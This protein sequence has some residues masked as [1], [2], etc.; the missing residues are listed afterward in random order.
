MCWE[1]GMFGMFEVPRYYALQLYL[2]IRLTSFRVVATASL[3][4]LSCSP[5]TPI[6]PLC[7]SASFSQLPRMRLH[8]GTGRRG[9]GPAGPFH[10]RQD[11]RRERARPRRQGHFSR[12]TS[13]LP[14]PSLQVPQPDVRD[15]VLRAV[16]HGAVPQGLRV[17]AVRCAMYKL[18]DVLVPILV[19]KMTPAIL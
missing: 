11:V 9:R 17:R 16:Q 10:S 7:P 3:C 14:G 13:A 4:L 2:S 18:I 15:R 8:N 1:V 12:G 6:H 19:P 5:P